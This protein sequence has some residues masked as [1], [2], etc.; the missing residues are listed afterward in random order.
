MRCLTCGYENTPDATICASCGASLIEATTQSG[1]HSV[2]PSVTSLPPKTTLQNGRYI[3]EK[4]L[5]QGGFGITYKAQDTLLNRPVAIKEFFLADGC[6]RIGKT[7]QPMGNISVQEYQDFRQKFI[8]EAQLLA[9]F[10]H[11]HI[12]KVHDCFEENNTAYMV[13]EFVEGKTLTE[14]LEDRGGVM[15]EDEA[16]RY[17]KQVAEALEEVHNASYLHRDIKPDNIVV[18]RNG[19]AVLLDFGIARQ[20]AAQKTQSMTVALT[21]EYAPLEQYGSQARFG[22]YT[23]IYALGATL[24]HLLTGQAPVPATDRVQGVELRPPHE[25]NR[26]VSRRVSD[27]VMKAMEIEVKNRPQTVREFVD[28]LTTPKPAAQ[29][30]PPVA[31]PAVSLPTTP[32][33]KLASPLPLHFLAKRIGER[34]GAVSGALSGAIGG[35]GIGAL[36]GLLLIAAGAII[37]ALAGSALGALAG[38][39]AGSDE[40]GLVAI[41]VGL[42]G[43][44]VLGYMVG[45]FIGIILA[46]GATIA[47]S[48]VGGVKG[49]QFGME[50][51][52]NLSEKHGAV[53]TSL[54]LS[55]I[56][57]AVMGIV[58]T[59]AVVYAYPSVSG[60]AFAFL[61][62]VTIV[63]ATIGSAIGSLSF[64]AVVRKHGGQ[65]PPTERMMAL[66]SVPVGI[67]LSWLM[68][69]ILPF[70]HCWL[71]VESVWRRWYYKVEYQLASRGSKRP[72]L[73]YRKPSY[74][75]PSPSFGQVKIRYVQV[76]QA[77]IR[78]GPGKSFPV[79]KVVKKG[80]RLEVIG[81]SDDGGWA[82]VKLPDG[83]IGY[84]SRKLLSVSP[85]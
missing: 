27:A 57:S 26:N 12:V 33:P 67:G 38:A 59:G 77:N 85:P 5:G 61:I 14:L 40:G 28:L 71:D 41:L 79:I 16:V 17:I 1:Q 21:K 10:N 47:A 56:T 45:I 18:R 70:S 24:Y 20:F 55:A 62:F 76:H 53:P 69:S 37:G 8:Q 36:A 6:A 2:L 63:G 46:L 39:Q 73:S 15:P 29:T 75:P 19:E 81:I 84:I 23:D 83:G 66:V 58:W 72:S 35:M 3:I 82:K 64:W 48:A 49:M 65:M 51:G 32:K 52:S 60:E 25:V 7:V 4:V 31:A 11:P 13:M 22:P 80:Q 68:F 9:K 44:A 30:S 54:I 34:F 78:S 50:F 74:A 42:I 43:G